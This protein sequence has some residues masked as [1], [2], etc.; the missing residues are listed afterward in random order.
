M[1]FLNITAGIMLIGHA[2]P[3]A[4]EIIGLNPLQARGALRVTLGRYNT[5]D[6]V[7]RFNHALPEA[8]RSLRPIACLT[9][10]GS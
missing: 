2:S 9:N 1:F 3:M 4:Q 5:E 7:D 10:G 6:D 8:V